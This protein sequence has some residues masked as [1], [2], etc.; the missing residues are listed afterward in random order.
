[1]IVDFQ[2]IVFNESNKLLGN[3]QNDY[4]ISRHIEWNTLWFTLHF[5]QHGTDSNLTQYTQSD[6][7][8]IR[9]YFSDIRKN[10]LYS[11]YTQNTNETLLCT[12]NTIFF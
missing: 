7:N 2:L 1:M 12:I 8:I 6:E 5:N 10:L 4:A 3:N 11:F 9:L